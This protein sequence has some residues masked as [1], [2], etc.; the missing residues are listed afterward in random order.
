MTYLGRVLQHSCWARPSIWVLAAAAWV[1]LSSIEGG[2]GLYGVPGPLRNA[3][4][5][6]QILSAF[7]ERA[8]CPPMSRRICEICARVLEDR[9]MTRPQRRGEAS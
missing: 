4:I 7:D 8:Y 2:S 9:S 6:P 1:I 5:A 3:D